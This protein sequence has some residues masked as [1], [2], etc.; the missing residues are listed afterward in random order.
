MTT[1]RHRPDRRQRR[2]IDATIVMGWCGPD[3][4]G[5]ARTARH[6]ASAAITL[7]FGGAVLHEARPDRLMNL[8]RSVARIDAAAAPA[9][10][11][12][13]V[14]R[15][16][17]STSTSTIATL[18]DRLQ[19][20][21]VAL[22]VTLHDL[23]QRSDGDALYRRRCNTYRRLVAAAVG[24][25]VSSEHERLLLQEALRTYAGGSRYPAARRADPRVCR[26]SSF[27]YRSIRW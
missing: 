26:W 12:L 15:R 19:R 14:R 4:H 27:H 22:A 18:A 7:G 21:R 13:A 16:R 6:I 10:E 20:R 9:G 5:I 17:E 3:D 8:G 1:I 23:P 25:A 24:V 2:G 11:R